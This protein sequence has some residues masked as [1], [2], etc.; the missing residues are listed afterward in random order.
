[1]SDLYALANP[2]GPLLKCPKSPSLTYSAPQPF[3]MNTG[4]GGCDR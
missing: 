2:V 4:T 3:F 1:M